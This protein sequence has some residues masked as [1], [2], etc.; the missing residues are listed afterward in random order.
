MQ[1]GNPAGTADGEAAEGEAAAEADSTADGEAEA[2][3]SSAD[4]STNHDSSSAAVDY[5]SKLLRYV[6]A[7]SGQEFMTK[8]ELRRPKPAEDAEP[9]EGHNP[10]QTPV[11]FKILDER[12]P[13]LEVG[14]A[15]VFKDLGCV[16][17]MQVK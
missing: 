5:S 7:S 8:L 16:P 4:G 17:I 11:T 9:A 12:M 10:E 13:L 3:D 14:T 2:A 6:A 15:A 1:Y